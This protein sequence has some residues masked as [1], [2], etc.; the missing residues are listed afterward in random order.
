MAALFTMEQWRMLQ[1]QV[2]N[3]MKMDRGDAAVS[4]IRQMV[5]WRLDLEQ[6]A[7]EVVAANETAEEYAVR[8]ITEWRVIFNSLQDPAE[9]VA[10]T[11]LCA[12]ALSAPRDNMFLILSGR[13]KHALE[14]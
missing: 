2:D 12:S 8:N 5:M 14:A 1:E 3:F 10:F 11:H 9:R 4:F 6:R 7:A 13:A